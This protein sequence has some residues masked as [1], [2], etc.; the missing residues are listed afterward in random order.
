MELKTILNALFTGLN[1]HI[2]RGFAAVV[3]ALEK[4]R[5]QKVLEKAVS[6]QTKELIAIF[7]E[8]HKALGKVA[9]PKFK[10]D[11]DTGSEK[12]IAALQELDRRDTI[13]KSVGENTQAVAKILNDL[14]GGIDRLGKQKFAVEV[15]LKPLKASVDTLTSQV[16]SVL[17]REQIDFAPLVSEMKLVRKSIEASKPPEFPIDALDA[18]FK[19]LKPKDSVKFDDQQMKGL[20]AALTNMGVGGGNKSAINYEVD[21][22]VLTAADTEYSYTF[23]ANTVSWTTKLRGGTGE[24]YWSSAPGK[25]PVSGDNTT[26]ITMSAAEARSQDNMEW[27]GKTLY[28]E[29]DTAAA[30]LEIEIFTM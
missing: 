8:F 23:P 26:Y 13:G 3:K 14:R 27:G 24:V 6:N 30:I 18:T 15:D 7:A 12:I 1:N 2:D 10:V 11:V 29:S 17:K 20:M 19:G 5:D 22:L 25:L 28:F 16:A 9:S 21:R 4:D